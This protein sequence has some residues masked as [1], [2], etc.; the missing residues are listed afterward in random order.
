MSHIAP[1][2]SLELRESIERLLQTGVTPLGILKGQWGTSIAIPIQERNKEA[3]SPFLF[4]F[5]S[6][7][8][9]EK[10][11]GGRSGSVLEARTSLPAAESSTPCEGPPTTPDYRRLF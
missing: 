5:A 4:V 9:M 10:M 1:Q 7:W 8:Q 3:G 6:E 2:I 11:T